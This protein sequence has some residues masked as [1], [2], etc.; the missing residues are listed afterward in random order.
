MKILSSIIN[1]IRNDNC[2]VQELSDK[3]KIEKTLVEDAI[4][5]LLDKGY[6]NDISSHEADRRCIGCS[7]CKKISIK[8]Y[9]LSEKGN[10]FSLRFL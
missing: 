9:T 7:K 8:G 5:F 1:E 10:R 4:Q 2:S 6:L 3:L